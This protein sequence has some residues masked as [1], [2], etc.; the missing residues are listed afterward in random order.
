M[1]AGL[2][3]EAGKMAESGK[4]VL[5]VLRCLLAF[6]LLQSPPLGHHQAVTIRKVRKTDDM[7]KGPELG[8][9]WSEDHIWFCFRLLKGRKERERRER[10]ERTGRAGTQ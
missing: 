1:G 9:L 6:C 5:V 2:R 4:T 8:S 7:R 10:L 3:R